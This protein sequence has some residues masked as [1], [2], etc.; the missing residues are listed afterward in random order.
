MSCVANLMTP[1]N[2]LIGAPPGKASCKPFFFHFLALIGIWRTLF[3]IEASTDFHR[4]INGLPLKLQLTPVEASTGNATSFNRKR[5]KLP[6][7]TEQA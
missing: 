4:S 6:Q 5:N 3:C 7:E 2:F 1:R